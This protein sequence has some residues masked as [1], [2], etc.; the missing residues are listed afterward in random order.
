MGK[1]FEFSL[2]GYDVYSDPNLLMKEIHW[3]SLSWG[4]RLFSRPWRPWK[5]RY[6]IILDVALD[7]VIFDKETN[8]L[9]AHPYTIMKMSQA[10]Y[11][12]LNVPAPKEETQQK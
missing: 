4:D 11:D 5:K 12:S 6:K 10:I 8:S 2:N 7:K 1:K 3:V 9:S